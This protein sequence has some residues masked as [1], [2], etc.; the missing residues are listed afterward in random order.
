MQQLQITPRKCRDLDVNLSGLQEGYQLIR[1][2]AIE[3]FRC[4]ANVQMPDTRRF[5]I[6][7]GENGSGKTALLEAIFVGCGGSPEIYIR[8]EAWRSTAPSLKAQIT[9]E[10]VGAL[11]ETYFHQFHSELGLKVSFRDSNQ[12]VREIR[13]YPGKQDKLS[14]TFAEGELPSDSPPEPDPLNNLTFSW[15]SP[16][17]EVVKQLEITQEGIVFPVMLDTVKATFL[18]NHT[19]GN[20]EHHAK[21][22]SDLD[23]EN[24]VG[25]V[26]TIMKQVFSQIVSLSIQTDGTN[27]FV[28][29]AEVEGLE[30]KIPVSLISAGINKFLAILLAIAANPHGV[31]LI[32]EIEN[33]LYYRRFQEM[34]LGISE[35]ARRN[36]CQLFVTTHSKEF[37]DALLPTIKSDMKEYCLARTE[38]NH[39]VS[40]VK[41]F[42]DVQFVG[43]LE[44]GFDVR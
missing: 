20:P 17:G 12:E 37:I 11:F 5:T 40:N 27:R 7:T 33:G 15:R 36:H 1:S 16:R 25:D 34:W 14:L 42:S 2:L 10:S 13:M 39:G 21:R 8:A 22:Y 28:L 23:K 24:K 41:S 44:S 32:D 43:A 19:I 31:V 26:L 9:K 38:W 35:L 29:Y 18:N 30:R 3:N 6:V 4:F